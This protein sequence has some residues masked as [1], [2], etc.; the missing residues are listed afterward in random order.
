MIRPAPVPPVPI[1]YASG[2]STVPLLGETIGASLERTVARFPAAEALVSSHQGLR[3]TYAQFDAAVDDE[4][5]VVVLH[6]GVDSVG[7]VSVVRTVDRQCCQPVSREPL[8]EPL[9]ARRPLRTRTA[10]SEQ[11]DRRDPPGR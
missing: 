11:D 5:L 7:A 2:T 10:V 9:V 4:L 6:V 3:Y 1:A 8:A